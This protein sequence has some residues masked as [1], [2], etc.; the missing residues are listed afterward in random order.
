MA[1]I[2]RALLS[3]SRTP[4]TFLSASQAVYLSTAERTPLRAS[5]TAFTLPTM[6]STSLSTLTVTSVP[7][8]A[9]ARFRVT[10]GIRSL[11]V[12]DDR[13]AVRVPILIWAS[14]G[15]RRLLSD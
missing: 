15:S 7:G 13:V 4:P 10:P 12:F 8:A 11:M 14:T 1:V 5:T 2:V 3:A 6:A 9:W